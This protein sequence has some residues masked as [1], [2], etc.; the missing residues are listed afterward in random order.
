MKKWFSKVVLGNFRTTR[1]GLTKVWEPLL[2]EQARDNLDRFS[3]NWNF[4]A[5]TFTWKVRHTEKYLRILF[6]CFIYDT[7]LYT[8]LY[9]IL[10]DIYHRH[11]YRVFIQLASANHFIMNL[12]SVLTA[13]ASSYSSYFTLAW[14]ET[15]K[16]HQEHISLI[17]CL[18]TTSSHL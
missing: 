16:A 6:Y 18:S 10:L 2:L 3:E 14:L 1:N 8:V 13:K 9:R 4:K 5:Q 7:L 15:K 17:C 11:K 12:K